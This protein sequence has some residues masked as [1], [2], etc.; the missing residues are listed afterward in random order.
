M[1]CILH[2]MRCPLYYMHCFSYNMLCLSRYMWYI[3]HYLQ[4]FVIIC[5]AFVIIC[6][7]F[8]IICSAF[9]FICGAFVVLCGAFVIIWSNFYIIRGALF[10]III[11]GSFVV[12]CGAFFI[13]RWRFPGVW[14]G[15]FENSTMQWAPIVRSASH[16]ARILMDRMD[17]ILHQL[18]FSLCT[19]A[20]VLLKK[21]DFLRR[22]GAAVHRLV[23]L[24][25]P[26]RK[27][28]KWKD[29]PRSSIVYV[30]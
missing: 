28:F 20:P 2:Y 10:V 23:E 29:R 26:L 21:S 7:T 6:R 30:R 25:N 19:A 18:S 3:C 13:M 9:V 27:L 11:R 17:S 14:V 1:R 8:V 15:A 22:T 4:R 12:I 16:S 5:G 24:G